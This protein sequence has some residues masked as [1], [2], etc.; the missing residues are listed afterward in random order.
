MSWSASYKKH[1]VTCVS[2]KYPAHPGWPLRPNITVEKLDT[3]ATGEIR[4]Y[5][6]PS[7]SMLDISVMMPGSE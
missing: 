4:I 6:C 5:S 7:L 2:Y 3:G 1:W